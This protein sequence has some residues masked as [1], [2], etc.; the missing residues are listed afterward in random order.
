MTAMPLR[1]IAATVAAAVVLAACG[2]GASPGFEAAAPTT[3][4][5][6]DG[7]TVD[8]VQRCVDGA[9]TMERR[10][11]E[12]GF[13]LAEEGPEPS[14]E[15]LE[16]MLAPEVGF[17]DGVAEPGERP[18]IL[19]MPTFDPETAPIPQLDV[20]VAIC[21]EEGFATE[22][23]LFGDEAGEEDWCAELAAMPIEEVRA[24]AAED[25]DEVVR[26]EFEACGLQSPLES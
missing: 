6:P 7:E 26:E 20:L 5:P 16:Q 2:G 17:E 8:V 11:A 23:E 12:E 24:F 15:E 14:E 19:P 10:I 13:E 22:A 18:A 9:S 21:V 4:L 25:G 1:R 3:A